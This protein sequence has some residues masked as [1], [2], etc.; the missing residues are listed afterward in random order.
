MSHL[1]EE[2]VQMDGGTVGGSLSKK[3][4]GEHDTENEEGIELFI[5]K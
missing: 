3:R 2:F 4:K 1:P 5:Y